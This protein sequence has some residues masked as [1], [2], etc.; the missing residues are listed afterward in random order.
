MSHFSQAKSRV[1]KSHIAMLAEGLHHVS[2]QPSQKQ[3]VEITHS[4]AV[5]GL[6][7]CLISAKPK[8]ECGNHCGGGRP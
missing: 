7:P 8:A 4:H 5:R 1:W 6:A 3:S 2:F